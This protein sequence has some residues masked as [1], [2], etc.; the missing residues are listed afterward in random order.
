MSNKGLSENEVR[1]IIDRLPI[2]FPADGGQYVMIFDGAT[3]QLKRIR[4]QDILNLAKEEGSGVVNGRIQEAYEAALDDKSNPYRKGGSKVKKVDSN[5]RSVKV[6]GK[7][8][9]DIDEPLQQQI[10]DLEMA[11]VGE[12]MKVTKLF[13]MVNHLYSLI[14][15]TPEENN[16]GNQ[17]AE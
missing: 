4:V 17:K 3:G 16:N 15:K 14:G 2:E 9:C 1:D 12:Q 13:E 10:D 7:L 6:S 5:K 8:I 11:L